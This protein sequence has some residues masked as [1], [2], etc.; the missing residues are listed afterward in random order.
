M[1]KPNDGPEKKS[2]KS[3]LTKKCPACY[4]YL[5]LDAD[6][7]HACNVRVGAIDKLG[8]A[9]KVVNH[10]SYLIAAFFAVVFI[11]VLWIGFFAE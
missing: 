4:T 3:S 5:P 9:A 11:A 2:S 1:S 7:C 10:R 8:F 6:R